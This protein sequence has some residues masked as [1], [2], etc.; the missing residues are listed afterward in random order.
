MHN[1]LNVF[2]LRKLS[3]NQSNDQCDEIFGSNSL[4]AINC[5]CM[6]S[7]KIHLLEV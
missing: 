4:L 1:K 5:R 2:Q 6:G 3:E 7:T